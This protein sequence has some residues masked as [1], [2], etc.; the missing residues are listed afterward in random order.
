MDIGAVETAN[1]TFYTAI[2]NADLDRMTEVW[3]EDSEV[4]KVSCVHPGWPLLS[5]RAEVLRSWALIMANT[6]YIQFVLTDVVTTIIGDVAVLSCAENI[7][8][9]GDAGDASFAAGKVVATNTFIRT[10]AGWRLW[11][12][13]GSPVLQGEDEE[14]EEET[15]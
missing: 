14:G 11:M 13:H 5:G 12:Y 10:P 15:A 7:L 3:A 1:Q 9:A 6:P 8:T 4:G 2:E